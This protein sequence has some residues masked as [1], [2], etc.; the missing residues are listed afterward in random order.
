[1]PGRLIRAAAQFLPGEAGRDS[2]VWRVFS[3]RSFRHYQTLGCIDVPERV[4]KRA[5]YG[6]RHFVQALLVRK[7]LW[8]HLPAER[9]ATLM[10]GCSTEEGRK[11]L[12]QTICI[13]TMNP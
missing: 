8:E 9:L 12:G 11:L 2:R 3:P 1:V 6:Y 7:L 4:G 5:V 10:A 13:S